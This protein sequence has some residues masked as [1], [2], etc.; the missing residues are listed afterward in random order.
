MSG[1]VSPSTGRR[2][3]LTMVCT[4]AFHAALQLAAV[5]VLE[6]EGVGGIGDRRWHCLTEIETTVQSLQGR[7]CLPPCPRGRPRERP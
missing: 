5:E 2:Y 1:R 7:R 3:P 6:V 4:V